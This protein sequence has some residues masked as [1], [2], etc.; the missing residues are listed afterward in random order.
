VQHS[1][2]IF[3][4]GLTIIY[5]FFFPKKSFLEDEKKVISDGLVKSTLS[6]GGI[7]K[8]MGNLGVPPRAQKVTD[9]IYWDFLFTKITVFRSYKTFLYDI[10]F[11]GQTHFPICPFHESCP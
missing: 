6:A 11:L 3:A 1:E 9:T 7:W 2:V 10:L 5:I 4:R 8:I